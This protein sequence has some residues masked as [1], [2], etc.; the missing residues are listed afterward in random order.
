[1]ATFAYQL[2]YWLWLKLEKDEI[3]SNRQGLKFPGNIINLFHEEPKSDYLGTAEIA[4]LETKLN[5]MVTKTK[6]L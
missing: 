2:S 4:A 1:M 3:K 6:A 5:D